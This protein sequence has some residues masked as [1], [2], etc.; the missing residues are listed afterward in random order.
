MRQDLYV[1]NLGHYADL[2]S[3]WSILCVKV[4]TRSFLKNSCVFELFGLSAVV[5]KSV[6]DLTTY[7][8][9]VA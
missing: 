9:S 5:A 2:C 8:R 3:E 1:S 7:F 4:Y 6:T